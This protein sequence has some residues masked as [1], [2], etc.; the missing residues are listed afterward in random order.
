MNLKV[1]LTVYVNII[2]LILFKL[3]NWNRESIVH[4]KA[5]HQIFDMFMCYLSSIP[6]QALWF[7]LQP[8]KIKR[9][10]KMRSP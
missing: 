10:V 4:Q 1:N 9:A 5:G 6:Q 3:V 2:G 7:L 8:Y